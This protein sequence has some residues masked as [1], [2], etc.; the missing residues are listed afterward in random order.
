[1]SHKQ[2][3]GPTVRNTG[4]VSDYWHS[5]LCLAAYVLCG[6]GHSFSVSHFPLFTKD[7]SSPHLKGGSISC[8]DSVNVGYNYYEA[9]Q[10]D[11]IENGGIKSREGRTRV[12]TH[13]GL[14][15]ASCACNTHG[16]VPHASKWAGSRPG[17]ALANHSLRTRGHLL[18]PEMVQDAPR[19]A[20]RV[21][22]NILILQRFKGKCD[23]C[24]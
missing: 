3:S 21:S 19:E 11:S 14:E 17:A 2:C 5:S 18:V 10:Y 9:K 16:D 8:Q 24:F 23:F 22:W 1:M 15:N 13:G 12:G 20:E 4:F 7:N 6:L